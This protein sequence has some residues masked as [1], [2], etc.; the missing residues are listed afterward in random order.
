MGKNFKQFV[1]VIYTLCVM[2]LQF[3]AFAS[4]LHT[5]LH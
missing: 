2:L 5:G 4:G 3:S 1:I